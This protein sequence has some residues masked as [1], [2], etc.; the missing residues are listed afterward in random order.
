MEPVDEA[1]ALKLTDDVRKLDGNH[2]MDNDQR[3]L[4]AELPKTLREQIVES[5]KNVD[6]AREKLVKLFTENLNGT[7]AMP[8]QNVMDP[9]DPSKELKDDAG[10]SIPHPDFHEVYNPMGAVFET[11]EH[12]PR[13]YSRVRWSIAHEKEV[14][15][16]DVP[17]GCV[18][19]S[20]ANQRVSDYLDQMKSAYGLSS[21]ADIL[22]TGVAKAISGEPASGRTANYVPTAD[23]TQRTAEF[24]DQMKHAYGLNHRAELLKSGLSK[25]ISGDQNQLQ[26]G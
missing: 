6:P 17:K 22:K 26:V 14:A 21:Q 9:A 15:Y 4:L 8:T 5:R 11:F 19:V 1:A 20:A 10:K 25:A 16:G 24:L 13:A 7:R 3:L 18:S 23:A 2:A 12:V